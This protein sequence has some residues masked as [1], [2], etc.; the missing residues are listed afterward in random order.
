MLT[1]RANKHKGEL[2]RLK[3]LLS[4]LCGCALMLTFAA[5]LGAQTVAGSING[6]VVD[7]SGAVIPGAKL[8]LVETSTN[9]A[10]DAQ[11][12]AQGLFRFPGLQP[13][14]YALT[15]TATGFKQST[16]NAI[17]LTAGET[18]DLGKTALQVGNV[19]QE[20]TVTAAVTPIQTTSSEVSH[21]ITGAALD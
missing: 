14:N 16:V 11:T 2:M 10:R 20:V 4:A 18:R 5:L 19:S 9:A 12:G 15:I 21:A 17:Q 3:R 6:T 7:S 8:H 1:M 13:G